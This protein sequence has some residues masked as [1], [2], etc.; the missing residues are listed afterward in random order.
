M[1]IGLDNPYILRGIVLVLLLI[2]LFLVARK[3]I[4]G[5]LVRRKESYEKYNRR[6]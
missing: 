6:K 4:V 3:F 2:L 5:I 1:K